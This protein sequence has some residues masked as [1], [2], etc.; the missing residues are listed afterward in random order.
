[1]IDRNPIDVERAKAHRAAFLAK[2]SATDS[3]RD[4]WEWT[5]GKTARGYGVFYVDGDPY[6]AHRLSW[7]I[8]H[9]F[10]PV[11]DLVLHLCGNEACVNPGHLELG[12]QSDN[13]EHAK[14]HHGEDAFGIP[15]ADHP[16]AKLTNEEAAEIRE[17]YATEALSQRALA[18]EYDVSPTTINKVV[19]EVSFTRA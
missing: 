3:P 2:A 4:C 17:R 18:D 8:F 19:N 7:V 5:G 15:G 12:D 11:E 10:D 14:V 16:N 6:Y 9:R 13:L 1:M